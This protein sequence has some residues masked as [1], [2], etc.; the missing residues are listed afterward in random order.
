MSVLEPPSPR[1]FLVRHAHAVDDAPGLGDAAR[2]LTPKGR[3]VMREV[4]K[5]L[6]HEG[7]L[8]IW[9]SPL[10]RAVQTAELLVAELGGD[11]VSVVPF[12]GPNYGAHE[13]LRA[14]DEA[15]GPRPLVVVGHEPQLGLLAGALLKQPSF[16]GFR[17][18]GVLG[19]RRGGPGDPAE[20]LMS[21]RLRE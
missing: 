10:V 1:L 6:R 9:T 7:R 3:S 5:R 20:V 18:C 2:W 11:D 4:A 12:L 8:T 13:A 17:K 21:V 19:L 14:I 16:P 15:R